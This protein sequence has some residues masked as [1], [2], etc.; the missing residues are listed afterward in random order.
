MNSHRFHLRFTLVK[1][2]GDVSGS[3]GNEIT[4]NLQ[5]IL[6]NLLC[7]SI[8]SPPKEFCCHAVLTARCL[9]SGKCLL[10]H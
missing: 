6:V 5:H 9:F 3:E 1:D 2:H 7:L 8:E 10:L 4:L